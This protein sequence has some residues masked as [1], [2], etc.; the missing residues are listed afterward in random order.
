[1]AVTAWLTVDFVVE[2]A[3]L[4]E[5]EIVLA[6]LVMMAEVWVV[7]E[8]NWLVVE[9]MAELA[10]LSMLLVAWVTSWLIWLVN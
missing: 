1:M 9:V 7:N 5:L 6:V 4:T 3:V 2:M 10:A 8:L